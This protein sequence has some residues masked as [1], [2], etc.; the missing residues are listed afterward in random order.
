M[1]K[2]EEKEKKEVKYGG[3]GVIY[4]CEALYKT[5][6]YPFRLCIIT[7]VLRRVTYAVLAYSPQ[8][9]ALM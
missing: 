7:D 5:D 8:M 2:S 9:A 3:G 6:I 4:V 1:W